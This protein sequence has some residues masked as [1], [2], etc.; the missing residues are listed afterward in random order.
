MTSTSTDLLQA[1]FT[2]VWNNRNAD[3]I[4]AL[5]SPAWVA[6]GLPLP[7]DPTL[8]PRDRFK[9][10]HQAYCDAFPDLVITVSQIHGHGDLAS[11]HCI[12]TGTH[13]TGAL[14]FP[15]TGQR[16]NFSGQVMIRSETGQVV[17]SWDGWNFHDM[18]AQLGMTLTQ[19]DSGAVR[20]QAQ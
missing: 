8:A 7:G 5:V 13:T 4:D 2:E 1:W 11:A 20:S 6:H 15:A 14:G 9:L 3:A 17:E 16:V 19:A 12:V 10:L 18:Y